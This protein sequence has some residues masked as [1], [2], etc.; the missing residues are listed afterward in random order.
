VEETPFVL[1]DDVVQAYALAGDE[2]RARETLAKMLP[3]NQEYPN[4]GAYHIALAYVALGDREE[5][6]DWLEK[7]YQNRSFPLPEISIDVRL[8]PLRGEERFQKLLAKMGLR[9]A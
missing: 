5:A 7:A 4:L 6:L 9:L 8:D 2:K 1:L 3:R